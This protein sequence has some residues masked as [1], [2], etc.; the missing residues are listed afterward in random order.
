M[1]IP[2]PV[3]SISIVIKINPIAACFLFF[4]IVDFLGVTLRVGL[5]ALRGS[6]LH[7]RPTAELTEGNR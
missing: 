6:W 4:F 3:M 1:I 5:F 7:P 2:Q